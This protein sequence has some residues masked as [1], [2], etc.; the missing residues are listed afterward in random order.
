MSAPPIAQF[1]EGESVNALLALQEAR[2]LTTS[3]GKPYVR[4]TLRDASGSIQANL[5]DADRDTFE[6]LAAA[7]AVRVRGAV[8]SF[9]GTLQ[10]KLSAIRPATEDEYDGIAFVP[11]TSADLRALRTELERFV[12]SVADEDYA[13]V[14][15]AF[16]DNADFVDRF[17]R[18]PAARQNHHAYIGG[19]LEHTISITRMAEAFA[20]TSNAPIDADLLVAGALL[21][22]VGKVEELAVGT[23]IEYT[24]TGRLVG[25]L[26]LGTIMV[27]DRCDAL[28]GFP[29]EKLWL[30]L[31]L[32]LSHHGR[33][34][35]G[36][37]VRPAIP[38]ALA[39][40]HLDNL[41]AKTV[42]ASRT[43]S[44][45]AD[46]DRNWTEYSRML[47]TSLYKAGR[48]LERAPAPRPADADTPRPHSGT[49][50]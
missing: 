8:E 36:S 11:T 34:E 35:F 37:P 42:A 12:T 27:K 21:H 38:E 5:W 41:D 23:T 13:S 1:Q 50:F 33:L 31:H 25:H 26:T 22:D 16:F 14:L 2:L 45:D 40:H 3:Q 30:L 19:L 44:E 39:L 18:A 47:E 24:D 43:I 28:K 10:L 17:A 15:H 49:L 20:R 9:R 6:A 32:I 48:A 7:Q 29:R 46:V 4:L